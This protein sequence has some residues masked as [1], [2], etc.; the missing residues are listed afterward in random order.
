MDLEQIE[1]LSIPEIE[2]KLIPVHQAVPTVA[3]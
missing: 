2:A 3:L 1:K